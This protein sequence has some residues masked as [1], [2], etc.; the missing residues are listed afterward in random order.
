MLLE[1]HVCCTL[2]LDRGVPEE[3]KEKIKYLMKG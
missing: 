1:K 3:I 2:G